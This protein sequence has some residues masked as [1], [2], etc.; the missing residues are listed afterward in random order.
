MLE[1][2]VALAGIILAQMTG[3]A[4]WDGI[5]SVIIGLIL[6]FTAAWLAHETKGLLIGEAAN[7]DIVEGIHRI[8]SEQKSIEK[9][10]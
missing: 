9:N 5:A 4:L 8:A 2:F 1:L 7:K 10:K 3:N 6:A